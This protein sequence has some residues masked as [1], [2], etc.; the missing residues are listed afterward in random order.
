MTNSTKWLIAIPFAGFVS[1][2]LPALAAGDLKWSMRGWP[3]ALFTVLTAGMWLAA[4]AFVDVRRP[5]QRPDLARL[6]IT[7]GL[8]LTVPVAAFDRTRG[9]VPPSLPALS[10]LGIILCLTAIALGISARRF[11]GT[12]YAPHPSVQAGEH[13]V[14]A[15]PYRWIRH[16]LYTAA[17]LW[18]A[19]WPM[20]LASVWGVVVAL[21]F[22]IPA[23]MVRIRIE[24]AA[25]LEA[26]GDE[27]A[28]YQRQTWRLIPLL[29]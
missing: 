24:E 23:A 21:A 3:E 8:L 13:L 26:Y 9:P 16:P 14:T 17:L 19:G 11:L 5:R 1:L 22:L 29:Y 7:A 4:T 15:G 12:A 10:P 28:R 25:L 2:G 6:L 20:I 18:S 27:F